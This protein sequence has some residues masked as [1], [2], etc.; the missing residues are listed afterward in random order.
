M[1]DNEIQTIHSQSSAGNPPSVPGGLAGGPAT[2][3][4]T[5]VEGTSFCVSDRAGDIADDRAQGVFFLDT[6]IISQWRLTVDG[7]PLR[8]LAVVPEQ[9]FAGTFVTRPVPPAGVHDGHLVLTRHRFIG[10]GMREDVVL[11]NHGPED[12]RCRVLLEVGGDFLDLFDVKD[13]PTGPKRTVTRVD[14]EG[15]LALTADCLQERG[16]RVRATG[17][18]VVAAGLAFDVLVPAQG[19]WRTSL[20]VIPSTEG[21]E[22]SGSFPLDAPVGDSRPARRSADWRA[23]NPQVHAG[24]ATL[25]QVLRQSIT[26]LGALRIPD[27]DHP[28]TDV[29][30]AGA[31]WFMALFGRDSLLTSWF[32]LPFAPSLAA[33]TLRTLAK[34]QGVKIDPNSEEE[35]GRILHEVRLGADPDRALGGSAV[36]Y[37][38]A[39]ATPLFVMLLDEAARW[40]MDE[41]EVR[42]LLPAADRALAWIT[43]YGDADGDGYVEYQRKTDRGLLNQGWKDSGDSMVFT[44]GELAE[45]PIALA[46]VQAYVYGAYTGRANLAGLLGDSEG[47]KHW[48]HKAVELKTAFNRDFWL[49][50]RGYY[51]MAL[52]KDKRPVDSLSSN[53]GHCL[54]TGIADDDKAARVAEHLISPAMFTGFGVRTLA[55]SSAAYNPVSYHNGSIWPHDNAIV[56]AGLRRYGFAREAARIAAAL[57]ETSNGFAG[58]L[59]ELFCG[60]DRSDVPVPVPYPTSCSPQAWAAAAPISL[61]RS[62]LG[63]QPSLA[64]GTVQ[65]SPALPA[66]WGRVVLDGI[67]L[68]DERLSIDSGPGPLV[69]GLPV[70][71]RMAAPAGEADPTS[72]A[73]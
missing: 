11:R 47:Q 28:E 8:S 7:S 68:G 21:G 56:V 55:T 50:G 39:D 59:P 34:H 45:A 54:W 6:R 64:Q 29:V 57:V 52:D 58:R 14:G 16:V 44:A 46:E 9:P 71:I 3:E 62:V 1:S 36:Y 30:A 66:S 49:A 13:G 15:E 40:G 22:I 33:G 72:S 53:I 41:A 17:A 70:E 20:E 38:T 65:V 2:G 24:N 63:L 73:A 23:A 4:F 67:W 60:F 32:S 26:D 27:P 19:E 48:L 12:R 43:T 31:P 25:E 51:A 61:L 35:P 37:G 5:L 42:A 18:T 69:G 10:D